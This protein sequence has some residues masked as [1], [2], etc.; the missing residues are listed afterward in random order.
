LLKSLENLVLR[1]AHR[2]DVYEFIG[3]FGGMLERSHDCFA[4][5]NISR[6]TET[7]ISIVPDDGLVRRK[8][9]AQESV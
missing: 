3:C 1:C 2:G 5:I 8:I 9:E 6:Y 7:S 4:Q